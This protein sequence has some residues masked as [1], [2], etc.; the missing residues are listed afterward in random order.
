MKSE[1]KVLLEPILTEKVYENK[2]KANQVVFKV[3]KD[4]NKL[5]IKKSIESIFAVTVKTVATL[6]VIGKP[7]RQGKFE[8]KRSNWKKAIITLKEGDKIDY[9]EGA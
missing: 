8:G 5:E 9:F 3:R 2:A 1:F 7:K 4:T 6:N